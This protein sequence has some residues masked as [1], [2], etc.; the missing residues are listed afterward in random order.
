M[1]SKL[2][3]EGGNTHIKRESNRQGTMSEA[4]VTSKATSFAAARWCSLLLPVATDKVPQNLW[5]APLLL[6]HWSNGCILWSID[7]GVVGEIISVH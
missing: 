2:E 5:L 1:E 4:G 7:G 6:L 3:R